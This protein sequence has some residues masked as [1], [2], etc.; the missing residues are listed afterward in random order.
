MYAHVAQ[1]HAVGPT[2]DTGIRSWRRPR[3]IHED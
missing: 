1:S 2:L 3:S